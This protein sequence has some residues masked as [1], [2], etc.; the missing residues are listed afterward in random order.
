ML[1]IAA[2]AGPN[3]GG[4]YTIAGWGCGASCLQWGVVDAKTGHVHFEPSIEIVDA[5][6]VGDDEF[7]R[8]RDFNALRFRRDSDLLV[9]LGAPHEDTSREGAAY[10]CWNG[11][12]F[13]LLKF[14]PRKHA[15]RAG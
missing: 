12:R 9:V 5:S 7:Q 10:Y 14:V 15:C 13:S 3:F 11:R 2:R 4:H 8:P 6:H 1:R